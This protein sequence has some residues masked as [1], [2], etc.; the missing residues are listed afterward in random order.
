M[1]DRGALFVYSRVMNKTGATLMKLQDEALGLLAAIVVA[2]VLTFAVEYLT[3]SD[4]GTL[5]RTAGPVHYTQ[6]NL[7]QH[8]INPERRDRAEAVDRNFAAL[9]TYRLP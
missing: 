5:G 3:G 6:T 9:D 2:V 1:L 8:T 4:S 7:P